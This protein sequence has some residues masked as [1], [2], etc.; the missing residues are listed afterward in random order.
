MGKR[1]VTLVVLVLVVVVGAAYAYSHLRERRIAAGEVLDESGN[2]V[3]SNNGEAKAEV[4]QDKASE[5]AS[6]PAKRIVIPPAG[7]AALVAPGQSA[8]NAAPAADSIAANPPNGMMFAGT[9]KFQ[10]Y[11][12]GD[13]TW[14]VNTANGQTCILFATEEQWRKPIVYRNGCGRG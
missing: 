4:R 1:V 3:S 11:R 10:V 12:Q 8:T 9:G 13:L 14:R 2:E 7:D 6:A 5:A